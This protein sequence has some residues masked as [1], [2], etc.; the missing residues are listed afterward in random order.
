MIS[1]VSSLIVAAVA[2]AG[3]A[4][5]S[6]ELETR[7]A[8]SIAEDW[9]VD[10]AALRLEWGEVPGHVRADKD[11]PFRIV[12]Q[13]SDGRFVVVLEPSPEKTAAVRVRAGVMDTVLVAGR[14]LPAGSVL[15]AGDLKR[16]VRLSWGPPGPPRDRPVEG[17]E[18]RRPIAAGDEIR[19]P[20]VA[21]AAVI[22]PGDPVELLW[23]RG[24]VRVLL[25]GVSLGSARQGETLRVRVQG[26]KQPLT[27]VAVSP[28]RAILQ[29]GKAR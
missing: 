7:I 25:D 28:G 14:S 18:V 2:A 4:G 11:V 12:G 19:W 17:W 20:S 21:P 15:A 29:S 13:G 3:L 24:G 5:V 27:A 22:A 8:E 6:P 16:D 26:R 10:A 23:T 1:F 9:K